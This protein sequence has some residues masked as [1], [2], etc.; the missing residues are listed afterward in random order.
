MRL[1][2]TPL[3]AVLS[4][5]T[6]LGFEPRTP[7]LKVWCAIQLCQEVNTLNIFQRTTGFL[8]VF[9]NKYLFFT[10]SIKLYLFLCNNTCFYAKQKTRLFRIGFLSGIKSL[11]LY[12]T[13]RHNNPDSHKSFLI[14]FIKII[15][16]KSCHCFKYKLFFSN[17]EYKVKT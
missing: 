14:S 17:S 15:C 1:C 16:A 10:K 5:V 3:V 8:N 4:F 6:P 2:A 7:T 12:L 13:F 9:Q 11:L